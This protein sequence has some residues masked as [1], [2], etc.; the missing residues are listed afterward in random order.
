LAAL[1]GACSSNL[2]FRV[3]NRL[4]WDAPAVRALVTLP[5]PIAWTMTDRPAGSFAVFVDRAPVRPGRT[6]SSVAAGDRACR[7][8]RSCP[9]AEYL[10]QRQVYATNAP[11][12][13]LTHVAPL[14]ASKD[15]VQVH[16]V[17]IVLLDPSG[18]RIGESAW[19][20]EF[21]LRK[22]SL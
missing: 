22:V 2:N 14:L 21:R 11:S 3:D 13:I 19:T 7:S 17:T 18:R 6:L 12:M 8:D 9:D 10:S 5:L 20:R 16:Q 15:G 4:H 1:L